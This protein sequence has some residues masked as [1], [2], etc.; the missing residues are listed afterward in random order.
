MDKLRRYGHVPGGCKLA[1]WREEEG[2]TQ[3]QLAQR[4]G[5]SP[6]TICAIENGDRLPHTTDTCARIQLATEGHVCVYDWI[7][8]RAVNEEITKRLPS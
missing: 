4:T 5:I 8:W 7:D 2:L 6:T 3:F 1:K